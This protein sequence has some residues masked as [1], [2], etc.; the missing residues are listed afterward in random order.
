MDV[1]FAIDSSNRMTPVQFDLFRNFLKAFADKF[2]L[3]TRGAHF[4]ASVYGDSAFSIFNFHQAPNKEDFTTLVDTIPHLKDKGSNIDKAIAVAATDAF[5]LKGGTRQGV[6]KVLVLVVAGNCKSC[7]EKLPE[8]IQRVKEDGVHVVALAIGNQVDM[9]ELT[10]TVSLPPQ[11][12][13]FE[14]A[15]VD[16]LLNAVFIQKVSEAI[17]LG[18]LK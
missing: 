2:I 14:A 11:R 9:K 15:T 5:S 12:N 1:H 7:T 6:P 4:S 18:E 17:C 13:L 8:A 3:S 10:D 16:K